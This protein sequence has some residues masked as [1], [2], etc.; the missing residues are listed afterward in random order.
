MKIEI[1][2]LL[3]LLNSSNIVLDVKWKA[4]SRLY[5]PLTAKYGL[6]KFLQVANYILGEKNSYK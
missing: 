2:G 5:S 4:A 6:E 1:K 3:A